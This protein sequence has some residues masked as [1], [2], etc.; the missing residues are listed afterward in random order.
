MEASAGLSEP[1]S[2]AREEPL[3]GLGSFAPFG[4]LRGMFTREKPSSEE[5]SPCRKRALRLCRENEAL[6]ALCVVGLVSHLFLFLGDLASSILHRS[7][8]S[9]SLSG[10]HVVGGL[11]FLALVGHRILGYCAGFVLR[12]L[13]RRNWFE[14]TETWNVHFGWIAYRGL[15]DRQQLV[16]HDV[17]WFNP[18]E[19]KQTPF[20]I[21]AKEIAISVGFCNMIAILRGMSEPPT[22]TIHVDEVMIDGVELY[23]ERGENG[24]INLWSAMGKSLKVD[25]EKKS[26]TMET[27]QKSIETFFWKLLQNLRAKT[28]KVH[29]DWK[30]EEPAPTQPFVTCDRILV[31]NVKAHILDLISASHVPHKRSSAV[32]LPLWHMKTRQLLDSNAKPLRFNK[33]LDKII[34]DLTV[35]LLTSNPVS[36]PS[37]LAHSAANNTSNAV[38][39]AVNSVIPS[40][41]DL[42]LDLDVYSRTKGWLTAHT[43]ESKLE[44]LV[45]V[46]GQLD[47]DEGAT[48]LEILS[49]LKK[50]DDAPDAT[51]SAPHN[52]H[53]RSNWFKKLSP[54]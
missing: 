1:S 42:R 18:A 4:T 11:L 50:E 27:M 25:S 33:F 40:S 20:V 35:V 41:L 14:Q 19:F 51:K 44:E 36:I 8:P 47:A 37:L 45:A 16:L 3:K 52:T 39:F 15:I 31:L 28:F 21:Y 30:S 22:L 26:R 7:L 17:I 38:S 34:D 53:E 9:T 6:V 2:K 24:A 48:T 49:S 12:G 23:L 54:F 10:M 43:S 5:Q 46:E 32:R 29:L 13:L